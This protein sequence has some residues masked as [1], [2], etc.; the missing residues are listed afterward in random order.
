MNEPAAGI[1]FDPELRD[2]ERFT[3]L[4][5]ECVRPRVIAADHFE[6]PEAA[7]DRLCGTGKA[8]L[9]ELAGDDACFRGM[10]CVHAL[11][12]TAG[13][14]RE[15]FDAGG[16]RACDADGRDDLRFRQFHH[17]AGSDRRR[18]RPCHARRV[19]AL[20]VVP[21][22]ERE[23]EA[24][25]HFVARNDPEEQ[26]WARRLMRFRG[27]ERCW[28][29]D[30]AGVGQRTLHDVVELEPVRRSPVRQRRAAGRHRARGA[31]Q[32]RAPLSAFREHEIVHDASPL[33]D[34]A[35]EAARDVVE[36]RE[37]RVLHEHRRKLAFI[38]SEQEIDEA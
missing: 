8:P 33:L 16:G 25:S 10:S 22:A 34:R 27:G 13:A 7:V 29:H 19:K 6:Q 20:V 5:V 37:H 3:E 38:Q 18:D 36:Q 11:H 14:L 31:V 9:R 2:C 30:G 26:P 21:G 12:H 35:V 32:R 4:R 24:R 1:G 28:D 23:P 17:D 15:R